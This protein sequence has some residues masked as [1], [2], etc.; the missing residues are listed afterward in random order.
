MEG[1]I[2]NEQ[3][4]Y[5]T[6][7]EPIFEA[8]GKG[9]IECLNWRIT[10]P[11][12]GSSL[13]DKYSFEGELDSW[14]SGKELLNEVAAHPD[15]QWWWGLLQGF[16]SN[17]TQEMIQAEAPIDIQHDITIWTLPVSMRNDKATI[18]IEAFDSTQ[19]IVITKD[20]KVLDTLRKTFPKSELLSEFITK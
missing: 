13:T 1:L 10:Y 20:E 7:L 14:I 15:I 19:S 12:C 2:L 17:Y 9:F 18:E 6:Y 16:E 11:E 5:V 8:L 4:K 3:T